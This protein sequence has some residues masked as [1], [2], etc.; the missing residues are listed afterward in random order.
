M[1]IWV[2]VNSWKGMPGNP[3]L[4]KWIREGRSTTTRTWVEWLLGITWVTSAGTILRN[5]LGRL[6]KGRLPASHWPRVLAGAITKR[7]LAC[8]AQHWPVAEEM[9]RKNWHVDVSV[10]F[11]WV[12][13]VI[14][15]EEWVSAQSSWFILEPL[16]YLEPRVPHSECISLLLTGH[17][18][19]ESTCTRKLTIRWLVWEATFS[20]AAMMSS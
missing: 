14:Q 15:Q 3:E 16:F 1:S 2:Q 20:I 8:P 7:L 12:G 6:W 10:G 11:L 4:W 18:L 17:C 9:N 13:W 5:D 19:E